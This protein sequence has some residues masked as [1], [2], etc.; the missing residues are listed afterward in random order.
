MVN[1]ALLFLT[2][3][4]LPA[5]GLVVAPPRLISRSWMNLHKLGQQDL[6]QVENHANCCRCIIIWIL[7]RHFAP[8]VRCWASS[9][10]LRRAASSLTELSVLRVLSFALEFLLC[11]FYCT[12]TTFF[13]YNSSFNCA[14]LSCWWAA[15]IA[16]KV[17]FALFED[18]L[19]AL[20]Y[21]ALVECFSFCFCTRFSFCCNLFCLAKTCFLRTSTLIVFALY[22]QL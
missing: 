1:E 7:R 8:S 4:I 15:R 22:L 11:R 14:A 20:Q 5:R 19:F 21:H 3:T 13:H 16:S 17:A 10:A 9:A 2:T 12:T 18:A 6:K